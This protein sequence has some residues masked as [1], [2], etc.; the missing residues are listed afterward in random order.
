MVIVEPHCGWSSR[1]C[2]R[3]KEKHGGHGENVSDHGVKLAEK[4]FHAKAY[5]ERRQKAESR[6]QNAPSFQD[7]DQVPPLIVYEPTAFWSSLRHVIL[8]LGNSNQPTICCS[9]SIRCQG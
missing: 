9:R 5:E 6:R 8:R 4:S 1:R 3:E 2:S 7:V